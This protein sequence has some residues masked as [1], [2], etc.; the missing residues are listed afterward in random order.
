MRRRIHTPACRR[1]TRSFCAALLLAG[2]AAVAQPVLFD[3]DSAP[4]HA[5]L[6][7]YLTVD[8]ATGY[9]SYLSAYNY[10]FSIQPANTLGFTPAGFAGNVIYPNSIYPADLLVSFNL[11]LSAPQGFNNVVIHYA[12]APACTDYGPIFM[13]DNM[14]VTPLDKIF[15]NGFE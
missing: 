4:V 9:F 15:A 8:V 11:T 3:F 14:Y 10:G 6:P 5:S 1:T 2:Q 7:M 12:A 13:A